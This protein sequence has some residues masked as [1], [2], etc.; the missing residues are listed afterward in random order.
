MANV[1]NNIFGGMSNV[2]KWWLSIMH[3][4]ADSGRRVRS[5]PRRSIVFIPGL[6]Q[7]A[8]KHA[9]DRVDSAEIHNKCCASTVYNNKYNVHT[10]A[11]SSKLCIFT[12]NGGRS[13]DDD[14]LVDLAAV[15]IIICIYKSA[16]AL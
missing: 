14:E 5:A 8:E 13:R 15:I 7:A 16:T 3:S 12:P 1:N 4:S 6:Y 9:V 10:S 11:K 2:I